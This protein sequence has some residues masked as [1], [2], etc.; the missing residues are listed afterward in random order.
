MF[1]A[2]KL[3]LPRKSY[4]NA[5]RD[6]KKV[7]VYG[8]LYCTLHN[9]NPSE[10]LS[11]RCSAHFIVNRT[12]NRSH[13]SLNFQSKELTLIKYTGFLHDFLVS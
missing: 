5:V 8:T 12:E 3:Q 4:T 9:A 7:W 1:R 6:V 11:A 10:R 2:K 13:N